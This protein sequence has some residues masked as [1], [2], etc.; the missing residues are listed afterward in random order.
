MRYQANSVAK[1]LR[2]FRG[3]MCKEEQGISPKWQQSAGGHLSNTKD[4]QE[5]KTLRGESWHGC[6][7]KGEWALHLPSVRE[8]K[9]WEPCRWKSKIPSL[10]ENLPE[11]T[12]ERTS[13]S[14]QWEIAKFLR[15][16]APCN[17]PMQWSSQEFLLVSGWRPNTSLNHQIFLNIC[18][19]QHRALGRSGTS[20]V[21]CFQL[22]W[23]GEE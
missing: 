15:N 8:V 2:G 19:C 5:E 6:G 1:W 10:G 18:I 4:T 9:S 16:Y 21:L 13:T 22:C 14:R 3:N 12:V 23:E 11:P 7:G 20:Q 17:N